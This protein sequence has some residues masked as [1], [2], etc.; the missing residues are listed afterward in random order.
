MDDAVEKGHG[1]FSADSDDISRKNEYTLATYVGETDS[2]EVLT[3]W[4]LKLR[5]WIAKLGAEVSGIER[6]PSDMRTNQHPRD[7]FTLFMSAN[8]C[9]ATLA[10]GTLG[11]GLFSLGWWDS[12]LCCL[13]F[14]LIGA[15]PGAFMA[16]FGPKLGLRTLTV[17]RYSFGWWPA[18]L[19]AAINGV[20]QVGW[21][22]VNT[23]AGAN[24]LYDVGQQS[25]P[26]SVSVLIIAIVA[27]VIV[28]F[29]YH[30]VHKYERFS[31]MVVLVCF[32]VLAGFG[33]K[34]F[35][36][37]PMGSGADEISS[38]LSFGTAIIGFQISWAPIAADYAVYMREDV[39]PWKVFA[40]MYNGLF[41]SQFL[42]ELLG[43]ALMTA[44]TGNQAFS[45]A[46]D[47]AG[48]GGMV[49]QVFVGYGTGVRNFG[50][51][52]EALLAFSVLGVVV[53]NLYS[54]SLNVQM[55][56]E[57]LM[58]VP[59]MVWSLV[60]GAICLAASVAGRNHLQSVMENFL[61]VIAYW[62]T[63]FLTIVWLEHIIWRRNYQYDVSVW[64]N[65][66]ELPVGIAAFV[67][68]VIG[69]VLAVLCMSQT[70]WVGP[71]ALK[72]GNPPYGTDI[73]WELALGATVVL[74]IPLRWL[75]RRHFGR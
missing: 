52:I 20:N 9:T 59:R 68:F 46:Y 26:S 50:F 16:T 3:P 61:N 63:P 28:T 65:P 18:K 6:V 34:H 69:T 2:G 42:V 35:V 25:L 66:R 70:W 73:S 56:S 21:A 47:A 14:N 38:V 58:I 7:L 30:V 39:E 22:M 10:F 51:F 29:G 67:V 45:D 44:V 13:F 36:N 55:I 64:N 17:P 5:S 19:I 37:V 23:I 24:F 33:A 53:T 62:L 15:L 40:W 32:C 75:E 1:A 4:N 48:V 57:K 12:F 27:I 71:I 72:V 74:Y 60:G 11:P 54:F 31:W 49:G 41:W 8:V 43:I